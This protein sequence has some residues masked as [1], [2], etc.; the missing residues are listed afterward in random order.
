M[1]SKTIHIFKAGRH[2]DMS[3]RT[4]EFSEA[5]LQA[6]AAAYDPGKWSAPLVVG[7]PTHDAPSYGDVA[8]LAVKGGDL[9]AIPANVDPAFAEL[10]QAGRYKSVSA[11]FYLPDSPNNPVP[12]VY[13]LRHVGF[14]GAQ[15]P[16]LKGLRPVQFSDGEQGV[17]AFADWRPGMLR[18]LLG[19]IR[20]FFIEKFGR[21]EADKT[22]PAYAIDAVREWSE[23][24]AEEQPDSSAVEVGEPSPQYSETSMSQTDKERLAALEAEN[25]RLKAEAAAAELLR[26]QQA[27][28]ADASAFCE[29]LVD[30]AKGARITPAQ[31]ALALPILA[32]LHAD[33]TPL[34]FGEGVTKSPLVAFKEFLTSLPVQV[35]FQEFAKDG[36]G[37]QSATPT[38]ATLIAHEAT[39][40]M[41]SH[42][43][44]KTHEAVA[45]VMAGKH[46]EGK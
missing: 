26:K 12:G 9:E 46:R 13:Y 37:E 21:E 17:V 36:Q 33:E 2:T 35:S 19:N 39:A 24:E 4:L 22:L 34:N 25:T 20:E 38:D 7:H 5:D 43:G 14:L 3:G 16:A 40:Y 30:P 18:T 29:T 41:E 28:T 23:A 6:S 1:S 31:K 32:R 42:P 8:A 11:S 44:V 15:P 10:V 27:A 45:I